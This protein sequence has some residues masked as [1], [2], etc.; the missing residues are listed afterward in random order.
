[1]V[2]KARSTFAFAAATER[3]LEQ[4]RAAR[5]S[6]LDS[7]AG[8]SAVHRWRIGTR[9]LL[10]LEALLDRRSRG[11]SAPC[12]TA[13]HQAFDAAGKLRD[14]QVSIRFL[15][16][17]TSRF[18]AAALARHELRQRL[19]RLRR[20]VVREVVATRT[21]ELRS[22]TAEWF[23]ATPSPLAMEERAARRVAAEGRA[24]VA[25]P[26][27]PQSP[28]ALHRRRMRIKRL[29]Y[30]LELC[31]DVADLPADR[32]RVLSQLVRQ[33]KALGKITDLRVTLDGLRRLARKLEKT[34]QQDDIRELRLHL[35]GQYRRLLRRQ[36]Q[37]DFH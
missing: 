36:M 37:R 13:V 30:M 19:P 33:Q 16:S 9:R 6:L 8:F 32:R 1:M 21:R 10:A 12:A 35:L 15:D 26:S 2:V 23:E 20:R 25:Q 28:R 7:N 24:L 34:S 3:T 14:A 31:S 18:V 11:D 29:R 22:I 5:R 17:L 4:W 27:A